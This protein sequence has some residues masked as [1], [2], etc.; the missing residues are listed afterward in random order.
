MLAQPFSSLGAIAQGELP[1]YECS[2]RI[3][4][5]KSVKDEMSLSF[6]D[7]LC[8]S[9]N[10][11]Q[12]V[13]GVL[14]ETHDG[15]KTTVYLPGW[16]ISRLDSFEG[17]KVSH[18]VKR[19]AKAIQVQPHSAAFAARPEFQFLLNQAI[20]NYKSLMANTRLPL[21]VGGS[22]QLI[23]IRDFSPSNIDVCY[24]YNCGTVG[25]QI[26]SAFEV[27]KRAEAEAAES[28][29]PY[30]VKAGWRAVKDKPYKGA[31]LGKGFVLGPLTTAA[32]KTPLGAAEAAAAAAKERA[33]KPRR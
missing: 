9:N 16:M 13:Y 23:T 30:F 22:V 19:T 7:L 21:L 15:D 11:D 32:D 2:D 17:I 6:D 25:L 10:L 18:A 28:H 1:A 31:F 14:Y 29:G 5:H 27:E 26:L 24:V 8:I 12:A 3:I 4:L 33:A 20:L